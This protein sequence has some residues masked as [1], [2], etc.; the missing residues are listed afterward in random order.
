MLYSTPYPALWGVLI[1]Q[2]VLS[3]GLQGIECR[4]TT[5]IA[6]SIRNAIAVCITNEVY[7]FSTVHWRV[8]DSNYLVQELDRNE[9]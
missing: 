4:F 8:K 6:C 5:A 7:C 1:A 9:M 2:P 3:T